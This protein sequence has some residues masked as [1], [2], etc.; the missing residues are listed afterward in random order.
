MEAVEL[1][2]RVLRRLPAASLLD[3]LPALELLARARAARGETEAARQAVAAMERA[4][5]H[6]STPYLRAR[7]LAAV[8]DVARAAGE[9]ELARRR[10]E[11]AIDCFVEGAAPYD[12]ALARL[13][14]AEALLRWAAP[15]TRRPP[16]TPRGRPSTASARP[17]TA[18]APRS[19][20]RAPGR[21]ASP[22]AAS[23]S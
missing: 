9:G 21:P 11:D 2:E 18:S 13:G 16:R 20:S 12:A 1:A 19:S 14:L 10:Y 15:S 23:A 7:A 6:Y 5:G 22:Q 3:R 4:A 8:A 17:A